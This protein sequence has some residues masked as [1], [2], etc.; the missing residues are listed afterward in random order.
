[1]LLLVTSF[2]GALALAAVAAASNGGI[3]PVAP[4]SPN[5]HRITDAYWLTLGVTGAVFLVIEA[6]LLTFVLSFPLAYFIAFRFALTFLFNIGGPMG[7]LPL[8][9]IDKYFDLFVNVMLG[10]SLVA[11]HNLAFTTRLLVRVRDAIS[12][13]RVAE[14]RAEV[15]ELSA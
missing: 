2:A 12:A 1:L 6:T 3:S 7:V 13:G 5:G 10:I 11:E 15:L 9:S 8:I 4:V 14:L